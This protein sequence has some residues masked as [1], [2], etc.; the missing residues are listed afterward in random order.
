M[1]F[2]NLSRIEP[3]YAFRAIETTNQLPTTGRPIDVSLQLYVESKDLEPI[4]TP[5]STQPLNA[6]MTKAGIT[7]LKKRA[8]L[9]D[10]AALRRGPH[11]VEIKMGTDSG[12]IGKPNNLKAYEL[13]VRRCA[14]GYFVGKLVPK[15]LFD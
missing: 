15:Q 2:K 6:V 13:G 14:N 9:F 3:T 7:H 4:N 8:V 11:I 1:G 12:F 10:P 5:Y